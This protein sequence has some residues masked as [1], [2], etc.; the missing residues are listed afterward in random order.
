MTSVED[1]DPSQGNWL[2]AQ[3]KNSKVAAIFSETILC[4]IGMHQG[5]WT[6]VGRS[7][8]LQRRFCMYCGIPQPRMRHIWPPKAD[9]EYFEDG[10][11][12]T[13][14]TCLRC[15]KT[16]FTGIRHEGRISFWYP[17]CKRCGQDLGGD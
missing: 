16:K 10:S 2:I 7:G 13:M 5:T 1:D 4:R 14:V 9:G 15:G 17:Y 12:E 6:T 3:I 8:C 11:C